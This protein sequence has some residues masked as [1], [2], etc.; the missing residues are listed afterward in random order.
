MKEL[1]KELDYLPLALEQAGAY[2]ES[3]GT[4]L[5]H[6][7]DLFRRHHLAL[8]RRG[9]APAEHPEAVETMWELVFRQIEKQSPGAAA[10]INLCAFLAPDD[11]PRDMIVAGA[12]HIPEPLRQTVK[13]FCQSS[14]VVCAAA[15]GLRTR[16][17]YSR[18]PPSLKK[19]LA[20]C[21]RKFVL[22]GNPR[23]VNPP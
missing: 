9:K 4:T 18:P 5:K 7:L 19:A 16:A 2:N 14:I 13:A 15:R 23:S 17:T 8:L 1:A 21:A 11:I 3:A 22:G 20:A 10:L 12:E 6:Y